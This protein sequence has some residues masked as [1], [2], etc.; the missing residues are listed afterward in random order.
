MVLGNN[1]E[2]ASSQGAGR[3]SGDGESR[4]Y[5]DN[6]EA[7]AEQAGDQRGVRVVGRYVLDS[8]QAE[9]KGGGAAKLVF[10]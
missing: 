9:G 10:A 3:V 5:Y 8:G 6:W 4:S 7:S 1:K 2:E